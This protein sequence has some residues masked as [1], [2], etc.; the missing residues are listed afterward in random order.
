[1]GWLENK[2][3]KWSAEIQ[4]KELKEF[5][6]KMSIADSSKLGLP[7]LTATVYRHIVKRHFGL[8]FLYPAHAVAIDPMICWKLAKQIKSLQSKK[9]FASATPIMIWLHT[10]RVVQVGSLHLR[11]LGRELWAQLSRGFPFVLDKANEPHLPSN[12]DDLEGF[13][14]IPDGLGPQT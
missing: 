7:V 6:C 10:L 5:L 12:L 13:N 1:M 2:V 3:L 14:C 11:P 9:E 8:D 4:E